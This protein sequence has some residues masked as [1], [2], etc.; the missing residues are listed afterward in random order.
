MFPVLITRSPRSV[1]N[2]AIGVGVNSLPRPAGRSG[3]EITPTIS[4]PAPISASSD[5]APNSPL[6]ANKILSAMRADS[7][8][9]SSD[10]PRT[11]HERVAWAAVPGCPCTFLA[12]K[13]SRKTS[14]FQPFFHIYSRVRPPKIFYLKWFFHLDPRYT[15][16]YL[17]LIQVATGELIVLI[18]IAS[19]QRPS[20]GVM[21]Q[22][23]LPKPSHFGK[24]RAAARQTNGRARPLMSDGFGNP[25]RI[26]NR[27]P[28]SK[29]LE[30]SAALWL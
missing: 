25:S 8:C 23:E 27:D 24:F 16:P 30:A 11:A 12:Q 2:R 6:P 17:G 15:S 28:H 4:C 14:I 22:Q 3:C 18:R 7:N 26:V 20:T 9:T 10:T 29:G 21:R 1:A 13:C 5:G 19:H